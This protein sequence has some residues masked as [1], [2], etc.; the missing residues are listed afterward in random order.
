MRVRGFTILEVM[1]SLAILIALLV[2]MSNVVGGVAKSRQRTSE[3]SARNQGVTAAFEQLAAALDTCVAS[4]GAM[5]SGIRGDLTSLRLVTS[6]VPARRLEPESNAGSPLADRDVIEFQIDGRDLV[7]WD[8]DLQRP[9][10]LVEDVTAVRFRYHDGENWLDNWDSSVRGLPRAVELAVWTGSW[11]EGDSA[12]WM[13]EIPGD[14]PPIVTG[15]IPEDF[16]AMD[17]DLSSPGLDSP[18][19]IALAADDLQLPKPDRKCVISVFNPKSQ[20]AD[21]DFGDLAR[22]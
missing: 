8:R 22:P 17:S 18:E 10:I 21:F 11:P 5:G 3:Q 15:E 19:G 9:S 6:R 7:L 14:F 2:V 1:L 16:T 13:P 20:D 4:D 12:A